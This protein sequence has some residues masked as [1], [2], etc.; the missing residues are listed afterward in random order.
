MQVILLTWGYYFSIGD[1]VK[2]KPYKYILGTGLE[3]VVSPKGHLDGVVTTD[4]SAAE[5][6]TTSS[7]TL[8][9][10][11]HTLQQRSPTPLVTL[12]AIHGSFI[13]VEEKLSSNKLS[14]LVHDQAPNGVFACRRVNAEAVRSLFP[15]SLFCPRV[16]GIIRRKQSHSLAIRITIIMSSPVVLL[17][18]DRSIAN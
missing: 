13:S 15:D 3:R 16:M 10:E 6:Q 11:E 5:P 9:K 4:W 18:S 2:G 17:F 8:F 7:Q 12:L 1:L 14:A